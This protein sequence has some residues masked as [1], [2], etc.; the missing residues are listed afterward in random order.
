LQDLDTGKQPQP[1]Q[2]T[3][4]PRSAPVE[5][6]SPPR[7]KQTGTPLGEVDPADFPSNVSPIQNKSSDSE[8]SFLRR[9]R[10]SRSP[11]IA[12]SSS[13]TAAVDPG[14]KSTRASSTKA[15]QNQNKEGF[16]SRA[17][18]RKD[19]PNI[20]NDGDEG[21]NDVG[22]KKS[23]IVRLKSGVNGSNREASSRQSHS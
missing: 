23:N 21:R 15:V 8:Q 18:M 13:K 16:R 6:M 17:E 20:G 10:R 3:K 1:P 2:D 11:P 4:T 5:A 9:A 12:K 22:S 19:V 14:V 7:R